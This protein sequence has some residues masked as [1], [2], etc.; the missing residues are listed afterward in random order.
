MKIIKIEYIRSLL[1][2]LFLVADARSRRWPSV[3]EAQAGARQTPQ[4]VGPHAERGS[5]LENAELYATLAERL[6]QP[7]TRSR[8]HAYLRNKINK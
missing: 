5:D 1:R 8:L 6:H 4:V 3:T 2:F 7:W